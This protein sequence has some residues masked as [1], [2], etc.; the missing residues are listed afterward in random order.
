MLS[1][2]RQR[3]RASRLFVEVH[4]YALCA[5][6]VQFVRCTRHTHIHMMTESTSG[7][8][9]WNIECDIVALFILRK[10]KCKYLRSSTDPRSRLHQILIRHFRRRRQIRNINVKRV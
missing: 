7:L 10:T 6:S 5:V 4:Y 1:P 3:L 9:A 8:H 2:K